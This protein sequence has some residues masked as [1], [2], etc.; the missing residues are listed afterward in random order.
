[1]NVAMSY[2]VVLARQRLASGAVVPR[3]HRFRD[4]T[5]VFRVGA[6][7]CIQLHAEFCTT[8]HAEATIQSQ[9]WR[10]PKEL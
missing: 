10:P 6:G 7:K 3:S 5:L 2:T 1:M 8:M 4:N 9:L